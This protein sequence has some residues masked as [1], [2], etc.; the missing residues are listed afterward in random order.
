[1]QEITL[2][3]ITRM[4]SRELGTDFC[5]M[6]V[7]ERIEIAPAKLIEPSYKI[8]EFRPYASP[9]RHLEALTLAG[10]T[11]HL[12]GCLHNVVVPTTIAYRETDPQYLFRRIQLA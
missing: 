12:W 5:S 10:P 9:G 3:S 7:P 11:D 2:F 4:K 8:S 1:M 6:S